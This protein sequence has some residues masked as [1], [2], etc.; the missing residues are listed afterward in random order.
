[1]DK[2]N[3]DIKKTSRLWSNPIFF[4]NTTHFM[5]VLN[6]Q[7][8]KI[9]IGFLLI[10]V[11]GQNEASMILSLTGALF[12]IPLIVF[13]PIA[14]SL[15]DK[16]SKKKLITLM[17]I[18]EIVIAFL[19]LFAFKYGSIWASCVLLFLLSTHSALLSPA[20]YAI[21]S[22]LVPKTKVSNACGLITSFSHLGIIGGTFLAS[23]LTE[24]SGY[25]FFIVAIFCL[26]IAITGF[27]TSIAIPT[28]PPQKNNITLRSF[29]AKDFFTTLSFCKKYK[30]FTAILIA[31]SSFYLMGAFIQLNLI[32]YAI[33]KLHYKEIAGGYLFFVVA[34]G[35][36]IGA[37]L[38]GRVFKKK[39]ALGFSC[40]TGVLL[41]ALLICLGI[42]AKSLIST[43]VILILIGMCGGLFIVPFDYLTQILSPNNKRGQIIAV[44]N[45]LS[46]GA[47][48]MA[49]LLMFVFTKCNF[50]PSQCFVLI[51]VVVFFCSIFMIIQLSDIILPFFARYCIKPF[52]RLRVVNGDLLKQNP[53]S[54]CL[55]LKNGSW[56]KAVLLVSNFPNVHLLVEN[57]QKKN[58]PSNKENLAQLFLEKIYILTNTFTDSVIPCI[59]M[60]TP[61]NSSYIH[62]FLQNESLQLIY[63]DVTSSNR[64]TVVA[65]NKTP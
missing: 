41:S 31:S 49:S 11:L 42:F 27:I 63:V 37:Y 12:V 20:K 62:S 35:M 30:Y 53:L 43:F 19:S 18:F 57:K 28:T 39:T 58:T 52:T 59:Y 10:R 64:K 8:F 47:A 2:C 33:T 9:V 16:F 5:G 38:S 4:L 7:L 65:F 26:L 61:L 34:L 21:I 1:M 6:D 25:N 51:G 54:S 40:L 17:K 29:L 32:P 36:A 22:E 60:K 24:K 48:L 50:N 56:K 3:N 13:S 46:F 15:A 23:F 55:I 45:F 44:I 14:G